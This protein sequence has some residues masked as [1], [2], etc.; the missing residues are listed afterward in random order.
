[1]GR[2]LTEELYYANFPVSRRGGGS[3]A[4]FVCLERRFY[5]E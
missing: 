3:A 5:I 1:M 4:D 2:D